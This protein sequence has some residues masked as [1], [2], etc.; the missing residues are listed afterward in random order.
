MQAKQDNFRGNLIKE[1]KIKRAVLSVVED[2]NVVDEVFEL[3]K[4]QS[5]Y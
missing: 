4:E 3:I 1:R 5:E 2:Q